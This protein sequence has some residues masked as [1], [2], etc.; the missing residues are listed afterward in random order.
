MT[1][2]GSLQ[3]MTIR[4]AKGLEFDAVILPGLG[5]KGK[6]DETKLLYWMKHQLK[7][8]HPALLL[9]PISAEGDVPNPITTYVQQLDKAKGYLEDGRLLYVAAT[10]AKHRLHLL[11]HV[12]HQ[13]QLENVEVK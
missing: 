3:L 7:S 6:N 9:A 13:A 1:A 5:R 10:R 2:D 4:K 8:G 12:N 11:G